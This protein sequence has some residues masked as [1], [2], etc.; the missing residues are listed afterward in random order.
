VL[1]NTSLFLPSS[2][3]PGPLASKAISGRNI[4]K[5]KRQSHILGSNPSI[6]ALPIAAQATASPALQGRAASGDRGPAAPHRSCSIG[7]LQ[8]IRAAKPHP[9]RS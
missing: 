5:M 8:A 3:E 7:F 6:P 9:C 4:E 1:V 2:R